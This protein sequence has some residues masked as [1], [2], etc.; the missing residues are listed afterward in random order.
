MP[1]HNETVA[2]APR[3]AFESVT[4][5]YIAF[6]LSVFLLAVPRAGYENITAF[7]YVLFLGS[8]A[9]YAALLLFFAVRGRVRGEALKRPAA[10]AVSLL[11]LA[12]LL[13]SAVS[14]L[15]SEYGGTFLGNGRREGLL[16]V[17]VYVFSCLLVSRLARPARWML[18][19]FGASVTAFCVLSLLQFTG[20]NPLGLFPDGMTYLDAGTLYSGEY[21][22]FVG[23]AGLSVA[24][25]SLAAGIFAMALIKLPGK[26]RLLLAVPLLLSVL[27]ILKSGV[28]AGA[29]A[30]GG[31]VLLS[32]P[33]LP[34]RE[35]K[36]ARRILFITVPAVII[37]ALLLLMLLPVGGSGTLYEASALLHG[38]I[39]DTFGSGRI[40]IWRSCLRLF[41]EKPLFGGG[42][43]TLGLRGI[44]PFMRWD[45]ARG[46]IKRGID[47][48]HNEYLNILVNQG[49][50]AIAAYLAALV[51]AAVR[52]YR[53]A[54]PAAA[55]AGTGVLFYCIQAFFGI[56]SCVSAPLFWLALG[57]F[58]RAE[59]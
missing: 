8:F 59:R 25:L 18:Y 27:V 29:V 39:H 6:L 43:D 58:L 1:E 26:A 54:S 14:A 30:L 15:L 51:I 9:L 48:A 2:A 20:L 28:S 41:A 50:F 4:D 19:L 56:S 17:A 37:L 47:A 57:L 22:G 32:L 36:T 13:F 5:G 55:I 40:Y 7:K 38:D 3:T 11:L 23:N 44:A 34:G 10:D 12:F 46:M 35:K 21:F 16:T 45:A 33:C 24:V 52:W 31:G 42:P 49:I 53:T